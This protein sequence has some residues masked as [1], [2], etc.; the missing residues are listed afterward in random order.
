MFWTVV[1]VVRCT[2]NFYCLLSC[3]E[4]KC[5]NQPTTSVTVLD[6]SVFSLH[7]TK[8]NSKR[9]KASA[10]YPMAYC[11]VFFFW[12]QLTHFYF[13]LFAASKIRGFCIDFEP[14]EYMNRESFF[15]VV[16][17]SCSIKWLLCKYVHIVETKCVL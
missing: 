12:R 10:F 4:T 14:G 17:V 16:A 2:Y 15:V 1:S 8:S 6:L 5:T 13:N 3:F 9:I 7:V 11:I